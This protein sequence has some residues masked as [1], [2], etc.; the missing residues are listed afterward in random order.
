M[1]ANSN[2]HR[3]EEPEGGFTFG[4][5]GCKFGIKVKRIIIRVRNAGFERW[6]HFPV[7]QLLPV[8]GIEEA[9]GSNLINAAW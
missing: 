3:A 7:V 8:N 2:I 1:K 4:C 9:V 5:A 6:N